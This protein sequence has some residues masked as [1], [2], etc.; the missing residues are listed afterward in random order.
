[1]IGA[2]DLRSA[3]SGRVDSGTLKVQSDCVPAD[4]SLILN[5]AQSH[6]TD[7]I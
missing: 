5:V 6:C 2:V 1:M 7:P 3:A 4:P